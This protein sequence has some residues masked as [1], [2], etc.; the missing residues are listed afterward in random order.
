LRVLQVVSDLG[1]GGGQE[2]VRTLARYLTEVDCLP[3]V[4]TL[5]DGPLRDDLEELGITVEVVHGRT[6]SLLALPAAIAELRRLRTDLAAVV[7]RHRS[8][9][10]QTHLLRALDFLV[11]T[12]RAEPGVRRVFW[13]FHS[14]RLGL[15]RD[16]LPAHPWLLGPKRLM[17][18]LLYFVAG[19]SVDGFV[20]VSQDVA[21]AVRRDF[22][23]PRGRVFIIPNGVDIERYGHDV[24]RAAV[25]ARV[26]VADTARLLTV[27]AKLI[28]YK[29]HAFLLRALPPLLERHPDLHVLLV[30]DGPLRGAL[31]A[32]IAEMGM[33]RRIH[34]AGNRRDV[35][36]LL[37]ASNLFVLP[38]LWEGLPMALLEAMA[39]GLPVV[40]TRVS[41][42]GE[43]VVDGESGLIVP[44]ADFERLGEA[45][46][47]LLDDPD[48]AMRMGRAA[49]ERVERL[50]S[51]R[52]QAA[53][54]AAIYRGVAG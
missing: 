41:G 26:G 21:A 43:V 38:S 35:S 5:R 12:L 48:R 40:A 18:R 44:T 31:T 23:P 50:F 53:R 54:Y 17:Y 45:I 8:E 25:R 52:A 20:A 33:T 1:V 7:A 9:V 13:T 19:R 46:G 47:T 34:L 16:Q 4:V 10:I 36:D 2:V 49:R 30:G 28:D 14:A 32:S 11:L 22:H 27:V 24:D 29:G 42:I 15:R 6:R 37:A 51:A 3:V 39:S